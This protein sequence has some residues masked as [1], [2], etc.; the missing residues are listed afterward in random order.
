[1]DIN[2][3]LQTAITLII[4][5]SSGERA[6]F[7]TGINMISSMKSVGH[8]DFSK[9]AQEYLVMPLIASLQRMN[10]RQGQEAIEEPTEEL[11]VPEI[12]EVSIEDA[13]WE[14]VPTEVPFLR[15]IRKI[16]NELKSNNRQDPVGAGS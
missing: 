6:K 13:E 16:N 9:Q 12:P 8:T 15:L 10:E 1:M 11:E 14:S 3:F 5:M 4:N 2:Q 7:G